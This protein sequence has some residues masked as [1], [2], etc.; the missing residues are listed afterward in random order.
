MVFSPKVFALLL[1][2]VLATTAIACSAPPQSSSQAPINSPINS[3]MTTALTQADS[4]KTI[5]IK[6]GDTISINL[7]ENPTTGYRWTIQS[8]DEQY[9]ELQSSDYA[10]A[11]TAPG[12]GGQRLFVFR[13]KA[14]GSV[15]LQL[16]EW[17][18]WEGD[19]S[20]TNRFSV[21]IEVQ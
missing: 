6:S 14:S 13:T 12:S 9:L 11:G 19:R 17:R 4:G 20:V 16:K 2:S 8:A 21:A 5:Q 7:P 3:P 15:D 10:G 18:E 1:V